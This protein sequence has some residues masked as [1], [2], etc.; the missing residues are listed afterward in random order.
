MLETMGV[1]RVAL[2]PIF[3]AVPLGMLFGSLGLGY[4]G[5]RFGR[6]PA[7]IIAMLVFGTV[8]VVTAL[9][10]SL[11]TLIGLRFLVG[12]GAGDCCPTTLP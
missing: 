6:K 8:G 7:I 11:P 3:S 1:S 4:I 12:L 10:T 9:S 5:D 2:S